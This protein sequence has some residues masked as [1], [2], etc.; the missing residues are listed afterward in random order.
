MPVCVGD[1]ALPI[2]HAS[3]PSISIRTR[4]QRRGLAREDGS[5]R[6]PARARRR[7]GRARAERARPEARPRR[8]PPDRAA[9]RRPGS[10][11]RRDQANGCRNAEAAARGPR[12]RVGRR[13]VR[14]ARAAHTARPPSL[15]GGRPRTLPS[16]PTAYSRN[17]DCT[18]STNRRPPSVLPPPDS[19]FPTVVSDDAAS[20]GEAAAS[21]E[22]AAAA[23]TVAAM[24]AVGLDVTARSRFPLLCSLL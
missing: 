21:S 3:R 22:V 23:A 13:P 20:P 6:A 19:S 17:A 11:R 2:E 14:I 7:R 16:V 4:L 1:D 12:E 18:Q 5:P 9:S 10:P 8:G 24:A 15:L